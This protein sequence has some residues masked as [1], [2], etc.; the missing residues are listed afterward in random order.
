[1]NT[2]RHKSRRKESTMANKRMF[3]LDI[4]DT[5]N[6]LNLSLTAQVLYFHLGMRADD[7]GFVSNPKKILRMTDCSDDDMKELIES[8]LLISFESGIVA[9]RDWNVHNN[10][11]KDRYKPTRCIEEIKSLDVQNKA[12]VRKKKLNIK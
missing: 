3:S 6:F 12:Y 5:D 2:T 10:V 9:I 1:M 4:V 7:D 8:G 11:P